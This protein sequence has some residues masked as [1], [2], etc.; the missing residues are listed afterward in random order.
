MGK[1]GKIT[2]ILSMPTTDA[3]FIPYQRLI[4]KSR[5]KNMKS[6][7]VEYDQSGAIAN[8]VVGEIKRYKYR[9]VLD[10]GAGTLATA[11]RIS[12]AAQNYLAV[13]CDRERALTLK[14]AGLHVRHAKFPDWIP[15][16]GFDLVVCSHSI[17]NKHDNT[18]ST[19]I[20]SA[21]QC[22][23]P[24]GSLLIVTFAGGVFDL[25]VLRREFAVEDDPVDTLR[26]KWVIEFAAKRSI[27]LEFGS[28]RSELISNSVMDLAR[29]LAL[30]IPIDR[31]KGGL[32]LLTRILEN[33]YKIME[34]CYVFPIQH[35]VFQLLQK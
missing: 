12:S 32:S 16:R 10:I 3:D 26:L 17:P 22:T 11:M 27:R 31:K 8:Y 23:N 29:V 4:C 33:N 21:L 19:F 20:E 13:E 24:W 6:G 28:I 7:Q 25:R 5:R 30:W 1:N 18:L 35:T 9:T 34:G 14:G 15:S 2:S